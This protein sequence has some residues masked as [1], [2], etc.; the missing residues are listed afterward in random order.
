M[1]GAAPAAS[2]TVREVAQ[3]V[4]ARFEDALFRDP[5]ISLILRR[6]ETELL[7]ALASLTGAER[8]DGRPLTVEIPEDGRISVPVLGEFRA[9]GS[10]AA[11]EAR[12]EERLRQLYGGELGVVVNLE[13]RADRVAFVMGEVGVPGPVSLS[14][15]VNPLTAI[16]A[17]GGMLV[18]AAP[19]HVV[20]SR[21]GPGGELQRWKIDVAEA[22]IEGGRFDGPF[23]VREN[24]LI[25]VPP[26]NVAVANAAVDQYFRR[27]L[28][29]G[30]GFGFGITLA[31]FSTQN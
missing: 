11:L 30:V 12:M 4:G 19:E 16:A 23:Q 29:I 21:Y 7:G 24:D 14:G 25:Y 22:L 18:S 8:G 28:P 15:P 1:I 27:M 31:D 5:T 13:E 10:P 20:L 6:S 26:S 2:L 17:A 3:E 9:E